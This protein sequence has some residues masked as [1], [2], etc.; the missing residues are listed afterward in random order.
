MLKYLELIWSRIGSSTWWGIA[1]P[2]RT[3][4]DIQARLKAANSRVIAEPDY[5]ARLAAMAVEP[6]VLSPDQ[7]IAFIAAEVQ[8]WRRVAT[9][10]NIQ[11]D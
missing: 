5:V 7:S 9:A 8:K 11:L 2:V 3:P 4:A 6:L 10:A 1:A